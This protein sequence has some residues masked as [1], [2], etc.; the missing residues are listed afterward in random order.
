MWAQIGVRLAAGPIDF[1]Q[2]QAWLQRRDDSGSEMLVAP[3]RAIAAM[4]RQM[5]AGF[6]IDQPEG[7]ACLP[8]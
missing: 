8:V 1:R 2:A 7:Q 5:T 3:E 4:R 6:R